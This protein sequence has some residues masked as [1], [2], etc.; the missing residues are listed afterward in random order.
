MEFS[1]F[2]KCCVLYEQTE[3]VEKLISQEKNIDTDELLYNDG[4]LTLKLPDRDVTM[5]S[6]IFDRE[7]DSKKHIR[8]SLQEYYENAEYSSRNIFSWWLI[9]CWFGEKL[10]DLGEPVFRYC[11]CSWWGICDLHYVGWFN[12]SALQKVHHALFADKNSSK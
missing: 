9:P 6:T 7:I 11:G 5:G 4:V 12:N 2:V 3:I 10:I 1:E 8:S